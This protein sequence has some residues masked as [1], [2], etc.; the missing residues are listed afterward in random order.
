MA[1]RGARGAAAAPQAPAPQPQPQAPAPA[2]PPPP[3]AAAPVPAPQ[4][5]A[6]GGAAAAPGLP[7]AQ[8]PAPLP[9]RAWA[10]PDKFS[11][12]QDSDWP[13]WLLHFQTVANVNGWTP[14]QQGNYIGLYLS[15]KAQSFYH[16]LPAAVWQGPLPAVIQ[17]LGDRFA[18]PQRVNV[19]RA[20]L[21]AARQRPDESLSDYCET[22]RRLARY[23]YP[24]LPAPVQD[25][26]AKDQ[27]V[28]SLDSRDLRHE[29]RR[30]DPASLDDALRIAFRQHAIAVTERSS[31]PAIAVA[32]S[33]NSLSSASD[34]LLS[35]VSRSAGQAG[36]FD[37]YLP[38]T[39]GCTGPTASSTAFSTYRTSVLALPPTRPLPFFL[40]RGYWPSTANPA[41]PQSSD[42]PQTARPGKLSEVEAVGRPS[43][44]NSDDPIDGSPTAP[45]AVSKSVV[46]PSSVSVHQSLYVTGC[47]CSHPVSMLVDT[48]SALTVINTSVWKSLSCASSVSVKPVD[49]TVLSVTGSTLHISGS[50]DVS[51][52]FGSFHATHSV[53]VADINPPMILGLDFLCEH[54]S[55]VDL[56]ASSLT[57]GS[58]T[59]P[60]VPTPDV[61]SALPSVCHVSLESSLVVP[62]YSQVVAAAQVSGSV[63]RL[64]SSPC[65]MVVDPHMPFL[66]KYSMAMAPTVMDSPRVSSGRVVPVRLPNLLQSA[67]TLSAGTVLGHLSVC[68]VVPVDSDPQIACTTAACSVTVPGVPAEHVSDL[69]ELSHLPPSDHARVTSLL[70]AF[71]DVVSAGMSDLGRTDVI[72]HSIAT[73]SDQ[74]I[75]Q[76]PRRVPLHQ[77]AELRTHISE[78]LNAGI[79]APSDSPWAAPIVTVRKPD[80]SLR[81]CVDYRKLNDITVKDAF[82]LPRVDDALDAMAGACC[83]TTL[84]LASGYWQVE[85]DCAAQA[86][87]AFVT[88]FGLYE[89]K[90]MPFGLCNAPG[91][92]Q[93]LMTHV[94]G[95]LLRKCCMVYLDDIVVFSSSVSQHVQHLQEVF[96]RLREAGLTLKPRKCNLLQRS[97]KYLGHVLSADGVSPDDSKFAAVRDWPVPSSVPDVR[98]FVGFASYYRR[99]IH[100]FSVIA[101]PLTALTQKNVSFTWTPACAEAFQELKHRLISAPILGYPD[102]TLRFLLDTDACD[103]GV[104]AVL[105]QIKPDKSEVVI[106]YASKVLSKSQRAYSVSK[107]ELLSV[108]EFTHHFRHYLLGAT[109]PFA[110]ITRR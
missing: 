109:F 18:P 3:P 44:C 78:L 92:F 108:V 107:R 21:K 17:A 53:I 20:E 81:L 7:P 10:S 69:F 24:T 48:G 22:V 39:T 66:D 50:V 103:V 67:I 82:P 1:T 102:P 5:Q 27:F 46:L 68:D 97:V 35:K 45:F 37:A 47:V 64:A 28:D 57:I 85:L 110:L 59:L 33:V 62:G 14:Q 52:S 74:P 101:A 87:S 73:T 16:S 25:V 79:I 36:T 65:S 43:T 42:P 56:G 90:C 98:R 105:S 32:N 55:N 95:D 19:Y 4:Q 2:A 72:T 6:A 94:L 49:L 100:H 76:A 104:G 70:N 99:F 34:P 75:K 86:K 41:T 9:V 40:P 61:S 91:T 29:V 80:N 88:P 8:P 83:F 51:L 89:W 11:G 77:Q 63:Q 106:A 93:R 15:D 12:S 26:L 23:A 38:V 58:A 30:L 96:V 60:L 71:P 31:A 84:D 13:T 54:P